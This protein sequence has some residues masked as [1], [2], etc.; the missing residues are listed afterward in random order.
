MNSFWLELTIVSWL[1]GKQ[2]AFYVLAYSGIENGISY[3]KKHK[4]KPQIHIYRDAPTFNSFPWSKDKKS[5]VE[6]LCK[7]YG[8]IVNKNHKNMWCGY[9][10]GM[11]AIVFEHGCPNNAPSILWDHDFNENGWNAL[12]PKR[13]VSPDVSSV[14]PFEIVQGDSIQILKEAG[15]HRLANSGALRKLDFPDKKEVLIILALV[16][17]GKRKR[18]TLSY[19]TKLNVKDCER[20]IKKCIEWSF[21]TEKRI[22]TSKGLAELNAAKKIKTRQQFSLDKGT[23]YYYPKQLREATYD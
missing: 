18:S 6:E 13:V 22:I 8:K 12:F 11:A 2:I 21:I 1:S 3:A 7:R 20:L 23:D 15:Q 5:C 17:M 9:K 16:A 4:S 19:A 10:E 14:F